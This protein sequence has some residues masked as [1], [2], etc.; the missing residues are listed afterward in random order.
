MA[1]PP[2]RLDRV[3]DL[4]SSFEAVNHNYERE[5][6]FNLWFVVTGRDQDEVA[7]VI[8]EIERE[9]G[10]AVLDLPLLESYRLDLG[11]PLEWT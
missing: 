11:F 2:E 5:H 4:V 10:L 1:V 7:A 3:A 6:R 9:T 8:A